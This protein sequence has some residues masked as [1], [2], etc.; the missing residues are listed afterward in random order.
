[1]KQKLCWTRRCIWCKFCNIARLFILQIYHI[2]IIVYQFDCEI[3]MTNCSHW[4]MSVTLH[5]TE[6]TFF[7]VMLTLCVMAWKHTLTSD[8]ESF[9]NYLNAHKFFIDGV[10]KIKRK[11]PEL[12]VVSAS[13]THN[14]KGRRKTSSNTIK[15]YDTLVKQSS[16]TSCKSHTMHNTQTN[17][18]IFLLLIL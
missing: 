13:Y 12:W 16:S 17:Y 9:Q 4:K 3:L 5:D 1:M 10:K 7:C 15:F 18:L 14:V 8:W 11:S 6:L 2:V